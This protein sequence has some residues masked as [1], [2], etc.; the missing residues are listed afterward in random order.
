MSPEELLIEQNIHYIFQGRDLVVCCLSPEH[1]DVHPSMRIDKVTGVFNCLSC[2]YKG[3]LYT[4]Y[5]V[6]RDI[7]LE[8]LSKVKEKL[9]SIVISTNGLSIPPGSI[10]YNRAEFR[11][12]PKETLQGYGAFTNDQV[13]PDRIVFP[14]KDAVGRI[15]AFNGRAL[16][17]ELP[18][19]YKVFPAEAKIPLFPSII[20]PRENSIILVEGL[21]DYINLKYHG[22]NNVVCAFGTQKLSE[23]NIKN[24]LAPYRLQGVQK[25]H[26]MFDGD[27]AGRSAAKRLQYLIEEHT[28]FVINIVYLNEGDDPGCLSADQITQLNEQIYKVTNG[29]K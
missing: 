24:K 3:S 21:F 13:Y 17:S 6:A 29:L 26:I 10:P 1:D 22:G 12:V 15:I 19:K 28:D 8:M 20:T 11:G 9:Q 14:I 16:Y 2:G 27:K 4:K 7:Q 23:N 18:P 5:Q 25:I